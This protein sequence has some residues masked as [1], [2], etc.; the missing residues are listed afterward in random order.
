L[1]A[2]RNS[3]APNAG[4]ANCVYGMT[5]PM[6]PIQDT[7]DT[8]LS[9]TAQTYLGIAYYDCLLCHNGRGHLDNI[10]LWGSGVTRAQAW[11]MAAFFSRVRMARNPA[12]NGEALY[13]SEEITDAA[14]GTYD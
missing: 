10:S 9:K 1:V 7:Y 12:P 6:G 8:C 13:L 11:Q 5:T 14:S 4:A 3:F 2:A